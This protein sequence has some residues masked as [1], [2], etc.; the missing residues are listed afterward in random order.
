MPG[1]RI[2]EVGESKIAKVSSGV[3]PV[4]NTKFPK[5]GIS[6]PRHKRTCLRNLRINLLVELGR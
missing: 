2:I 5:K 6:K 3:H 1:D 4:I